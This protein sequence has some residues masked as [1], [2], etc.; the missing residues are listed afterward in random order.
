H[1]HA[2]EQRQASP[3]RPLGDAHSVPDV[4]STTE[5]RS[6]N[7]V[8]LAH[9]PAPGTFSQAGRLSVWV[10]MF[11]LLAVAV[12]LWVPYFAQRMQYAT[13]RGKL[14]AEYEIAQTALKDN[15]LASFSY[16]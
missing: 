6:T 14:L 13:S 1:R 4:R 3:V 10:L 7:E 12:N 8:R 2:G 5:A 11:C 15:P 9:P 16:A